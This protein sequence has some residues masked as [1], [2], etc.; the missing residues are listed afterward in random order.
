MV[1]IKI[2]IAA[3]VLLIAGFSQMWMMVKAL[4][5]WTGSLVLGLFITLVS[6]PIPWF[7]VGYWILEGSIPLDYCIYSEIT[8]EKQIKVQA[9]FRQPCGWSGMFFAD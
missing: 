6:F 5:V 1:K 9:R 7:V 3:S 4:S 2:W 8:R